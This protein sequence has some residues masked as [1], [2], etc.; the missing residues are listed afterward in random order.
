MPKENSSN[1]FLTFGGTFPFGKVRNGRMDRVPA[2]HV[3]KAPNN[4]GN[5]NSGNHRVLCGRQQDNHVIAGPSFGAAP[6]NLCRAE[7]IK[8]TEYP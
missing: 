7:V 5:E 8:G 2:L 3:T 1:S 4:K 6:I